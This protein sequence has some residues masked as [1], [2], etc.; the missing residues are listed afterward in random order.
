MELYN[1][2]GE[3]IAHYQQLWKSVRIVCIAVR[4]GNSWLTMATRVSLSECPPR[5]A[6][7]LSPVPNLMAV[8]VDKTSEFFDEIVSCILVGGY[9]P[10]ESNGNLVRAYLS[11][12]G[13]GLPQGSI[14]AVSWFSV[15]SHE[16]R[17]EVPEY[18]TTRPAVTLTA[19]GE[20]QYDVLDTELRKI[21]ESKLRLADPPFDGLN[22]LVSKWMPGVRLEHE[23]QAPIQIVA[24]IPFEMEY[25][26]PGRLVVRGPASAFKSLRV[27]SFFRPAGIEELKIAELPKGPEFGQSEVDGGEALINWPNE[28]LRAKIIL[29]F[30]DHE[31]DSLEVNRWQYSGTLSAAIDGYFDP[32]HKL[33]REAVIGQTSKKNLS[34]EMGIVRLLNVLGIPAIWYGKGTVEGRPDLAAGVV[35]TGAARLVVLGECTREKPTE[36]FSGL[37][38]RARELRETYPNQLRVLPVVF[39][40][41]HVT[42]SELLQAADYGVSLIGSKQL[43]ILLS[44]L[45][46][47]TNPG[48]VLDFL[49]TVRHPGSIAVYEVDS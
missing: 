21:V 33:L 5:A 46:A 27:R 35:T 1:K 26:D 12:I 38:G 40:P 44:L 47:P 15:Y 45:E 36:K 3:K 32:A 42:D 6:V 9:V 34:F 16:R 30:G 7:H 24:P 49:R 2:L 20:R 39:T 4:H 37:R 17:H 14:G 22:D 41:S 31:V 29:F 10:I 8:S 28:S 25:S 19:W 18:G 11:R 13:A 23:S 43:E 48:Q